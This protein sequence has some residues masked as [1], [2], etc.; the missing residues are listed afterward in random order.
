M[1]AAQ[2]KYT[3]FESALPPARREAVGN[4][5]K[6]LL[7]KAIKSCVGHQYL[8]P[9]HVIY[10]SDGES[11]HEEELP[12]IESSTTACDAAPKAPSARKASGSESQP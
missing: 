3:Q 9:Q 12:A 10:D 6:A 8:K 11:L 5:F 4:Q 1:K 7:K 2:A